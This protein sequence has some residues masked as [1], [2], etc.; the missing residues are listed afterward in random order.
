MDILILWIA[1]LGA[2]AYGLLNAF[3]GVS[4]LR[5]KKIQTWAAYG[6][7]LFGLVIAVSGILILLKESIAFWALIVGLA[8][9]HLLAINNG[10]KMY[11]KINPAHH[12]IRLAVSLALLGLAYLGLK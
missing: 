9:I 4:Q 7:I 2:L 6:L 12:L 10:L 3:A 11:K 5:I 1:A 8:G